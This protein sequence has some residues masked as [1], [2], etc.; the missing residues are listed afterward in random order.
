M[1][2]YPIGKRA[3]RTRHSQVRSKV[4]WGTCVVTQQ[5]LN[6]MM[7]CIKDFKKRGNKQGHS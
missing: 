2:N 7:T 1:I 4:N 6:S 5:M 3:Q